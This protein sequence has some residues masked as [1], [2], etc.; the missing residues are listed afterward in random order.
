MRR[1]APL[2]LSLFLSACP[3]PPARVGASLDLTR[4]AV[5]PAQRVPLLPLPLLTQADF[6]ALEERFTGR[7]DPATLFAALELLAADA[8]PAERP[9]D[10]LL[11][12][13]LGMLYRDRDAGAR[14]AGYL[15]KALAI[16]T[17]LRDE[18]PTSPHTLFL[19]GYIPFAFL[20]GGPDR[21]MAVTA[22][23]K[24]FASACL[25]QWTQLLAVAPD[26]DGPG[27]LDAAL[28]RRT[29]DALTRAIP[30]SAAPLPSVP[31]APGAPVGKDEIVAKRLFARFEAAPEGER[32]G[33]CRDWEPGIQEGAP[34]SPSELHL[35]LACATLGGQVERAAP[36]IG[37]LRDLE[38]PAFSP[39][40]AAS[41]LRDRAERARVD[42][43]LGAIGVTCP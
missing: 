20:G 42:A 17:R 35:D 4:P 7:R 38:G 8:R 22:D 15:Q 37:R 5:G 9:E 18:A 14:G 10:V 26:Y 31:P 2:A 12:M 23:T 27:E 28:V 24:E 19:Q 32:K 13:R 30:A 11:L 1:I 29:V 40:L 34:R 39:C 16:G 36:I 21:P 41:R 6:D 25:E 3:E 33:L 43:A